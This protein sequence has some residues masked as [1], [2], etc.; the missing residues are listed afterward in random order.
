MH[1]INISMTRKIKITKNNVNSLRIGDTVEY[2]NT[3]EWC[4][5]ILTDFEIKRGYIPTGIHSERC[6]LVS[7]IHGYPVYLI[8][9]EGEITDEELKEKSNNQNWFEI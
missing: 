3:Y 4:K 7:P 1:D 5:R 6:W 2:H 8:M 9:D